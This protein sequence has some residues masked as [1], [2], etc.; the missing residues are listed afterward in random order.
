MKKNILQTFEDFL[1]EPLSILKKTI[2]NIT[3]IETEDAAQKSI[4]VERTDEGIQIS[5]INSKKAYNLL[6]SVMYKRQVCELRHLI[7]EN[8]TSEIQQ[9][10][11]QSRIGTRV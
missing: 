9:K 10:F 2:I 5:V 7:N 11:T 6:S 8:K 3:G 1:R 4:S